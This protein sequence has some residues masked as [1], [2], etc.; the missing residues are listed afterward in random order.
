MAVASSSRT[1]RPSVGF[2]ARAAGAKTH[3]Q[4]REAMWGYIFLLPWFIGLLVFIIGPIIASAYFSLTEY[5]VLAPP[6]W[7]GLDNYQTAF[8]NDRQFWPSLWRTLIYSI[9]VV[10]LGLLGSLAM[11]MLLNQR[12]KGTN[13][14]RTVFFL[15]SLT[16]AVALAV[17][18]TWLFH[19]TVGPIN[20]ILSWFGIPGP[21]WL[22]SK[23]WAMTA[24]ILITLWAAVG[25]NNM[26]IFLAGLQGVPQELYEASDI[27]GASGWSKFRHV[28]IPMI[29]PT[30]LFNLILGVI[31]ALKVF[32][33]AF[34]ATQ[35]GPSYATWF[36]A[37]HIYRQAFEYFRMGYGSALAWV[38]VV[39]LL[40]FT[41][42]QMNWSRKWVYYAG[43]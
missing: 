27:D 36:F 11:A 25:G 12:V 6:Q 20:L 14:F 9:A 17:L 39:M 1:V 16:P 23:D 3:F 22:A 29:S 40:A 28:T 8:F 26:L 32:T 43:E 18:W 35:G 2:L 30:L 5:S 41:F 4:A 19:P 38:F 10:P 24:L 31:G 21:G 13:F 34:V 15:P 33:L 42:I 7:V 37:L